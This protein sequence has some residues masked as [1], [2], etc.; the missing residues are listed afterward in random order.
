MSRV[1]ST[2]VQDRMQMPSTVDLRCEGSKRKATHRFTT[3]AWGGHNTICGP[4]IRARIGPASDETLP[5]RAS[6]PKSCPC[7][8][9]GS[10]TPAR[11]RQTWDCGVLLFYPPGRPQLRPGI[12]TVA[13]KQVTKTD[14]NSDRPDSCWRDPLKK[15]M[16]LDRTQKTKAQWM[17]CM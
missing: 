17:T 15:R 10:Q 14:S 2:P 3:E 6:V 4:P 9:F 12:C 16:A 7:R 13:R 1:P 8:N 11:H 5:S